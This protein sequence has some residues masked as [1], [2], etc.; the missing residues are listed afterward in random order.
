MKHAGASVVISELRRQ[1]AW[2]L[3][4][5]KS[6]SSVIR[7]CRKCRRFIAAPAAEITAPLP[8]SRV[9]LTRPFATT[10]MDLG[11]PL[12]LRDGLRCGSYSSRA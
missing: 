10:G 3:R 6:V 11:G 2:V 9:R 8:D 12:F 5:K 4:P 1:G 7:S